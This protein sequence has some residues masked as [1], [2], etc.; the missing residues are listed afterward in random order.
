LA[1]VEIDMSGSRFSQPEL[2]I[3]PGTEVVWTNRD[4]MRH[5]ATAA[6]FSFDSGTME[7]GDTFSFVFN[8]PGTF[9]YY[10]N[11]HPNMTGTIT[12][13]A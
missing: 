3:A 6:D 11:F 2:T 1:R 8:T 9:D 5:S 4:S 7:E 13:E 10:C 12:V